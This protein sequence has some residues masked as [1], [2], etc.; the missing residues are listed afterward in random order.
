VTH[1]FV[2]PHVRKGL[3]AAFGFIA[4]TLAMIGCI[5]LLDQLR[6]FENGPVAAQTFE[7]I[8]EDVTR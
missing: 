8:E 1:N 6:F 5:W 4:Y 7:V 2:A 3:G